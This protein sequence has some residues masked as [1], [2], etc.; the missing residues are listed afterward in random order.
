MKERSL[1]FPTPVWTYR[2][3]SNQ[4]IL[5]KVIESAYNCEKNIPSANN[6]NQ[7]GYQSPIFGWNDLPPEARE[8][9]DSVLTDFLKG[10]KVRDVDVKYD[11]EIKY[12]YNINRKGDFNYTHNHPGNHL[13]MIWYLTDQE[14]S[15]ILHNPFSYSRFII[16]QLIAKKN[17]PDDNGIGVDM[18]ESANKG[19]VLIFPADVLHSVRAHDKDSDR[20]SMSF[21]LN[22]LN[23]RYEKVADGRTIGYGHE[24]ISL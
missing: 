8:Y 3:I 23:L 1:F 6:T 18:T 14:R 10:E 17:L 21:N 22:F 12:W 24:K 20:V 7:G 19:D 9:L 5:D 13:V 11:L 15:L 2:Y 16:D 4:N